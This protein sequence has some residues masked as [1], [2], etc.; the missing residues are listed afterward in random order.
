MS[1]LRQLRLSF[2]DEIRQFCFAKLSPNYFAF[3]TQLGEGHL[4]D[5]IFYHV[6]HIHISLSGMSRP[7]SDHVNEY[8]IDKKKSNFSRKYIFGDLQKKGKNILWL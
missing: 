4:F 5:P 2:P 7:L 6:M 1:Y 8:I 3:E